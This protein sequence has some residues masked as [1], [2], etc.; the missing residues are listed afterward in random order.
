MAKARK[1][2]SEAPGVDDLLCFALYSAN[3]AMNRVYKPLLDRFN[4]TYP[5][6]LALT[7]LW[8]EDN[9]TVSRM[10]SKLFLES[11]TL[12]P[13]LKRLETLDYISRQRDPADERQ[14]R[15]T[16]TK[17]G[18]ALKKATSPISECIFE[19]TALDEKAIAKLRKQVSALR[20]NLAQS[21]AASN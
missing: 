15:V 16:L 7:V 8:Q 11:N 9:Q 17:K 10:G 2:T 6:Y 19:A 21:A 3:H 1:K 4:L 20:E 12:T 18:K 13:L 14:V 5:Q